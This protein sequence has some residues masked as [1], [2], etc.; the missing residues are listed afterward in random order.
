VAL[1]IAVLLVGLLLVMAMT[2]I[3]LSYSDYQVATNESRSIQAL[4]NADAGVEE[5]KMRISPNAPTAAKIAIGTAATWRAYIYS[6]YTQAQIQGGLDSTYG[7]AAPG[8]TSSESTTNYNYYATVQSGTDTVQWG[9]ARI[10]HKVDAGGN[11]VY[12]NVATGGNTTAS[13]QTLGG[14]TVYNPP[15]LEV[16]AEGIQGQVRRMISVEYQP[17]VSTT[18]TTTTVETDP[19]ANA[20]HAKGKVELIGNSWTDS[21]DSRKGAYGAAGNPPKGNGDVSTDSTTAAIVSI[22]SGSTVAG[23]VIVGPG[24]DTGTAID[25]QGT[26]T[27]DKEVE[28]AAWTMPLSA[29]PSG[30]TNQGSLSI[31]GN[32]VTTLNEGTYWFSS[33]SITGNGQLKINGAVKIYVTGSID[34]GGNGVAT[35]NNLPTNLLLYGTVDPTDSTK[36]CTSVSIHGNGDLYGGVYAPEADMQVSGNGAVYGSLTG[37]SAKINGNGGF[38]YDEALGDIGTFVTESSSTTYTTTGYSR[39]SWREIAF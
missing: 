25:N 17:I 28:G 7:K 27:G 3:N 1:V 38:H 39:Y 36:K 16:T 22:S 33:L 5:A 14:V 35:A 23:D 20:V 30:V 29:I 10:Q 9:W 15:I 18:N 12:Q 26:I 32:K 37:K 8:Y 34:I 19:F 4:Y 13:S 31:S 2:M 24:G 11:I 6:G 21:Y